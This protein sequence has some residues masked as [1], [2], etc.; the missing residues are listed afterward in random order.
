MSN[1]F[2]PNFRLLPPVKIKNMG[3]FEES[4]IITITNG[5]SFRFKIYD[6]MIK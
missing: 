3:Q 5:V 4:N 6:M 2:A 1:Q